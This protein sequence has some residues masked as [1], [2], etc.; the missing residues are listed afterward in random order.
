V[1][2]S[3]RVPRL[4][5]IDVFGSNVTL[6]DNPVSDAVRAHRVLDVAGVVAL[7]LLAQ[8]GDVLVWKL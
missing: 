6:D 8:I 7:V 5:P 3:V 4:Q 2:T 1:L